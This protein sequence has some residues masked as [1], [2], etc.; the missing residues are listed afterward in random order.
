[1]EKD[2]LFKNGLDMIYLS[3]C[4]L[5]SAVPSAEK[6]KKMDLKEVYKLSCRHSM[7]AV[8]YI[9]IESFIAQNTEYRDKIS[10]EL[11][12]EWKL[13]KSKSVRNLVLFDEERG[14]LTAF[15][16]ENKIWYMYLK[17]IV[18]EKFYPN[19]GMRQMHDNDILFDPS[20]RKDVYDYMLS[21]GYQVECYN[22]GY[23]DAYK[24]A[25]SIL[26]EMHHSLY[27]DST[28][29]GEFNNYYRNVKSRLLKDS[30]NN[31]GYHFSDEDYYVHCITHT[32]KHF[33]I[34]GNGI[35]FLMDVYVYLLKKSDSLDYGYI[36]KQ[37]D[38]LGIKEFEFALRT[39]ADKIFSEETVKSSFADLL[40][41]DEK[42]SLLFYISSG[43]FGKVS[44]F[45]KNKIE[46]YRN[47]QNGGTFKYIL[48]R[49]FP[50]LNFYKVKY[51]FCY[52]Y[53]IF[54]PFVAVYRIF[55]RSIVNFKELK[56][57]AK[58][59]FKKEK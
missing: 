59:L 10:K 53:K 47:E 20:R 25:P 54:I 16:E 31:F 24:K 34:G 30:D 18:I 14:K 12:Q 36:E 44:T 26:F 42:E 52:K 11:L 23:P 21:A 5:N 15:L 29:E 43:T 1:M 38:L 41:E 37:L 3:A 57:E 55:I 17:G 46:R 48:R 2:Q 27:T 22:K 19:P 33:N 32:Y 7:Q 6:I 49:L 35:R 45:V 13:I 40:S 56:Y 50:D 9:A 28:E 4:A 51:P 8:T 58:A 39:L